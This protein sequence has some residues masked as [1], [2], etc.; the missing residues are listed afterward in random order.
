MKKPVSVSWQAFVVPVRVRIASKS[1]P[2]SKKRRQ[3]TVPVR[4]RIASDTGGEGVAEL[5]VTVPVR[6]RIAS[7]I[8]LQL[9]FLQ[10]C[11][12]PREGANCIEKNPIVVMP[13]I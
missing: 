2:Q 7:I 8:L 6:V 4:V 10:S 5:R 9:L 11:Y 12:S 13:L 3:V 1:D